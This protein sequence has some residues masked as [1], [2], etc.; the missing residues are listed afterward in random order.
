MGLSQ[1]FV[2]AALVVLNSSPAPLLRIT[3]L[4]NAIAMLELQP[5]NLATALV[6]L[7]RVQQNLV[8]VLDV[9]ELN[10]QYYTIVA[11]LIVANKFLNDQSYTLKTWL[12]VLEKCT[13]LGVTLPLLN[14]LE[15]NM[16]AS[17]DYKLGGG[18]GALWDLLEGMEV[19]NAAHLHTIYRSIEG[20]DDCSLC[21]TLV[22]MTPPLVAQVMPPVV[23]LA[24]LHAGQV[25]QMGPMRVGHTYLPPPWVYPTPHAQLWDRKMPYVSYMYESA[26]AWV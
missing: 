7:Y 22:L 13:S 16:L 2:E 1:T 3:E 17:L 5:S 18:G 14:Q 9:T 24:P 21:A 6:F 15:M 20:D 12:V 25:G 4:R 23:G 8:T 10:I 26:P 19:V 11:A